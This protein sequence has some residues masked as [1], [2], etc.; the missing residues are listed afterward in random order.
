MAESMQR[1]FLNA[2]C[3]CSANAPWGAYGPPL[4]GVGVSTEQQE[5]NALMRC[6]NPKVE[7]R[8]SSRHDQCLSG[9]TRVR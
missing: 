2:C 4:V 7:D 5:E 6:A 1:D 9:W 8:F 3:L